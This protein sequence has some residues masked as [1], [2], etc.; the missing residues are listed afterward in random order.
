LELRGKRVAIVDDV[1]STGGSMEAM[2][3]ILKEC[4][5]FDSIPF[6]ISPISFLLFA[7]SY[8]M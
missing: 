1:V 4:G 5:E 2:R 7:V 6:F 8:L 3:M